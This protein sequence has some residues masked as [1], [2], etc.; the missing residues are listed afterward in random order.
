MAR[1]RKTRKRRTVR[2][3]PRRAYYRRKKTR[4]RKSSSSKKLVSTNLS[5]PIQ[6]DAMIYG[7]VRSFISDKL[8]PLTARIPLGS[9]AD[10]VGM[11]IVDWLGVKYGSGLIKDTA[12]KGL[13]I[14]NARVGEYGVSRLLGTVSGGEQSEAAFLYG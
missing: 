11:G 5:S 13:V 12:Q 9:L 14:E 1:R 10:E 8:A 2:A 3:K 7:G 4:R 6:Y